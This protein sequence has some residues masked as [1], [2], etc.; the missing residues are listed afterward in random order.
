MFL[1]EIHYNPTNPRSFTDF[2]PSDIAEHLTMI[3]F[4]LFRNVRMY[5][6][7]PSAFNHKEKRKLATNV[8]AMSDRFNQVIKKWR[9]M[10]GKR[11]VFGWRRKL[12]QLR[13]WELD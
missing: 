12:C 9:E 13:I 6:L 7:M 8:L 4:A 3:E 1:K 11:S 2:H 5:E 10:T